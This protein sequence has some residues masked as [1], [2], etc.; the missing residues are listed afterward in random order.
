MT[1]LLVHRNNLWLELGN[2]LSLDVIHRRRSSVCSWLI[3]SSKMIGRRVG[4]R[5]RSP[6]LHFT[7]GG[8]AT[9]Q[10]MIERRTTLW[11]CLASRL[12]LFMTLRDVLLRRSHSNHT[13]RN[14][15]RGVGSQRPKLERNPS[16]TN[17]KCF[18]GIAIHPHLSTAG[19]EKKH[20]EGNRNKSVP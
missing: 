18:Q 19:I 1:A 7:H 4:W 6:A 15:G 2:I 10:T 17:E 20:P 8:C 5:R 9:M 13:S 12:H 14:F 3:A 16:V 11:P